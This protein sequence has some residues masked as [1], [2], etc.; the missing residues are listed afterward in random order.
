MAKRFCVIYL[1]YLM[2]GKLSVSQECADDSDE[3]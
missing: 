2:A 3:H 1:G